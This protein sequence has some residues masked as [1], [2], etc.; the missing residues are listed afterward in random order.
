MN[1]AGFE[2]INGITATPVSSSAAYVPQ[3]E[4]PLYIVCYNEDGPST[5]VQV[6]ISEYDTALRQVTLRKYNVRN[7]AKVNLRTLF[8]IQTNTGSVPTAAGE[9]SFAV[10]LGAG[11]AGTLYSAST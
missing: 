6:S 1:I 9:R 3:G 10:Q 4:I 2:P 8:P 5:F 11:G 7:G